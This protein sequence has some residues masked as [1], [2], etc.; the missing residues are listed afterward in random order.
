VTSAGT[1]SDSD[2]FETFGTDSLKK[3]DLDKD[4]DTYVKAVRTIIKRDEGK[5]K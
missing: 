4:P 2:T 1:V 5:K 3:N